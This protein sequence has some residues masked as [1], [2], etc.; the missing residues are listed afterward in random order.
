MSS[1]CSRLAGRYAPSPALS[2][3]LTGLGALVVNLGCAYM[4]AAYGHHSGSLTA[5][6]SA[7]NDALA[8][9]IIAAGL[10]TTFL[11]HLE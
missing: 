3:T 5:F 11:R 2:L 10:V 1:S 4:L 8:I 9:A 6:L 7:R